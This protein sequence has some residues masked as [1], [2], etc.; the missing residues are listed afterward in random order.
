M[1]LPVSWPGVSPSEVRCL[2]YRR[3]EGGETPG[4]SGRPAGRLTG[5]APAFMTAFVTATDIHLY[6]PDELVPNRGV[7]AAKSFIARSGAAFRGLARSGQSEG[8][9]K[10]MRGAL[11]AIRLGNIACF[12]CRWFGIGSCTAPKASRTAWVGGVFNSTDGTRPFVT[13]RNTLSLYSV[14]C[15][16]FWTHFGKRERPTLRGGRRGVTLLCCGRKG[17]SPARSYGTTTTVPR[18]P[19]KVWTLPSGTAFR[20][21]PA[22]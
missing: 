1:L 19:L 12:L 3:T 20:Y 17:K 7:R 6:I 18:S 13:P 16:G 2:I 15:A 11:C 22:S 10:S 8:K 14:R 9:A 5:V 21:V 4:I